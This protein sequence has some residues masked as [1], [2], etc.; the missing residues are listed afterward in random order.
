M[1]V[2]TDI[3]IEAM[4]FYSPSAVSSNA[5]SKLPTNTMKTKSITQSYFTMLKYI[6]P[7]YLMVKAIVTNR[8]E[9]MSEES[10]VY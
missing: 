1:P 8:R 6:A 10:P 3:R 7:D 9:T 4:I 5:P 2:K